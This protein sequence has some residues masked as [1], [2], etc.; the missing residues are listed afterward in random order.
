MSF[1]NVDD[2]YALSPIQQGLLV[3]VLEADGGG[4]YV[5]QLVA[6]VSNLDVEAFRAAWSTLV[7]RHA[8]LRTAFLW[9]GLD[10]PL[11]V[12]RSRVELPWNEVDWRRRDVEEAWQARLEADRATSFVLEEA[13]LARMMLARVDDTTW[14]W[15][16][17]FH[18]LIL[19]GWSARLLLGELG[20]I[21]TARRRSEPLE[22]ASPFAYRD[23]VAFLAARASE[24]TAA[25]TFWRDTLAGFD[26]PTRLDAFSPAGGHAGWTRREHTLDQASTEALVEC[27]R[28]HRLTLATV[29]QGAWALVLATYARTDDVVFGVTTAGRPAELDGVEG[30]VGLFINSLPF[31]S[32]L[33]PEATLV[34]WLSGVQRSS[35]ALRRF[36]TTPLAR[37]Q[38]WS[39]LARED[40]LFDHLLVIENAPDAV[41]REDSELVLNGLDIFERSHYDFAVLVLP[42]E[43]LELLA[44]HDLGRFDVPFVDR[45]LRHFARLLEVFP[46]Q[47]NTPIGEMSWIDAAD[48][49]RL[50]TT[51]Q[52]PPLATSDHS[53]VYGL[54][55]ASVPVGEQDQHL[56]VICGNVSLSYAELFSRSRRLARILRQRGVAPDARVGLLIERSIDM[57]I[58]MVGI[59]EAGGA[60]VP[61]DI[62]YPAAHLRDVLDD[63]EIEVV[64][65]RREHVDRLG[66]IDAT[67][68]D[69]DT[70]A[71]D[72]A[73]LVDESVPHGVGLEN[74][75]YV[76]YTSGSSGRPKGVMVTHANLIASTLARFSVYD[77][78]VDRFLL[79]S[80]FAFDSSVAGIFWTLA[81]GGTL[82]LPPVGGEHDLDVLGDLIDRHAVTHTLCLPALWR[83]AL[84]ELPS[85]VLSN[86][87]VAVVA[88]EACPAE[89][90]RRHEETLPGTRLYN[91]YGPTEA[92]VWAT[93]H[94]L[95]VDDLESGGGGDRVSIGRPIPGLRVYVLDPRGRLLPPGVAGE[96]YLAGAGI[97]RGYW[98]RPELDAER[99]VTVEAAGKPERA[100][101]TGDLGVHRTDGAL[102]FLGR[103]DRQVKV[104]GY[105]IET[106]GVEAALLAR[107]EVDD[108]AVTVRTG[109]TGRPRLLAWVVASSHESGSLLGALRERVEETLPAFMV[110]ET[111]VA[112][113]ELPRRPNGKVDYRALPDV[114][115][116]RVATRLGDEIE[117]AVAEVWRAV[118]GLDTIGADDHFFRLGG[119]SILGIQVVSRLRQVGLP[120]KPRDVAAYPHLGEL[121]SALRGRRDTVDVDTGPVT[122]RV[123]LAPIQHWFFARDLPRAE[124]WNLSMRFALD[125]A[126]SAAVISAAVIQDALD[127]CIAHHDQ[128]RARFAREAGGTW[129]QT[130][131]SHA[132]VPLDEVE[133][134]QA[135]AV[136]AAAAAGL[137]LTSGPLFRAVLVRNSDG[138]ADELVVI[139]HHLVVDVVSWTILRDDL[140]RLIFDRVDPPARTAS[141]RRW[142]T[143]LTEHDLAAE[144]SHW[145]RV[146]GP[147]AIEIPVDD[148]LAVATEATAR[149]VEISVDEALTRRLSGDA[150]DHYRA[151]LDEILLAAVAVAL[152]RWRGSANLRIDRERH[153]RDGDLDLSR[154]VGWCT[155]AF[156]VE[157]HLPDATSPDAALRVV[158]DTLRAVPG[159]GTGFGVLRSL[160]D[161]ATRRKMAS[162]PESPV[163]FNYLG[164]TP[165]PAAHTRLVPLPASRDHDRHPS[166]PRSHLIEINAWIAD[167]VLSFA[168]IHTP[169]HAAATIERLAETTIDVLTDLAAYDEQQTIEPSA[170]DFPD[171]ELDDSG[172]AALFEQLES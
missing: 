39:E 120:A 43:R 63:A 54:I 125:G 157:L 107:P 122:G 102:L 105:R 114:D 153:G 10:E 6:T 9:D 80:S 36:E 116:E 57:V 66:G 59:L 171:A 91:E 61:L 42:G 23:Y 73:P 44:V 12:V 16:F 121:A 170:T 75:A 22:L 68:V 168:W 147:Q 149:T 60:Y 1:E 18:H 56:A 145:T 148:A 65:S 79:L 17:T 85:S 117:E 20:E 138:Q 154:T 4:V 53:S 118:L 94:E 40:E 90:V 126:C 97:A 159:A 7:Q 50:L 96:I 35:M 33:Q 27:A 84:D 69:L 166:Q 72:E 137:D 28:R 109:A 136:L 95:T 62:A 156:P 70:F 88:G 55:T 161:D 123:P 135:T 71:A 99:F 83:L 3:H 14:R 5:D 82:V 133:A 92:T 150:A 151:R 119:D 81:S 37:I 162:L 141:Y 19:D 64:V 103:V 163:L 165:K 77:R 132:E 111:I 128:L 38:K 24:D 101:R 8:V 140:E 51:W 172:L 74:L 34:E 67:L 26:S 48:R 167:E 139:A 131:A 15:L 130:I 110:P 112:V 108:A 155:A 45:V 106:D 113:D 25:E 52:S 29:L 47:A 164:R 49:E 78:P 134:D 127:R 76:I 142:V 146:S 93:A 32:V 104:R 87:D 124:H 115:L 58:G 143:H 158:K 21:Y 11:Q 89:V 129:R 98:R 86:L 30:G 100:Y 160:A 152:N 144:L 13:P 41:Q 46:P 169:R 2:V 31:R